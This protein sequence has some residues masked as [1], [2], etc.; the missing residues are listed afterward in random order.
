MATVQIDDA[1][2]ALKRQPVVACLLLP[3]RC[4][5][6]RERMPFSASVQRS[7]TP[8]NSGLQVHPRLRLLQF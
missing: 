7:G 6:H 8:Q 4:R 1:A 3:I 5:S 2:N